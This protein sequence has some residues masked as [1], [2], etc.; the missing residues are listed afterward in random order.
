[1]RHIFSDNY[2][3]RTWRKLWL[4]LAEAQAEPGLNITPAQLEALRLAEDK[5]NFEKAAEYEAKF[6]HEVMAHVH[7]YADERNVI[8]PA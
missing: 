5:I 2:K 1:M 8:N 7:A 4:V 6:Q 3:I